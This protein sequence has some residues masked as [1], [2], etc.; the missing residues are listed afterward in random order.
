MDDG[1]DFYVVD[2]CSMVLKACYFLTNLHH[3]MVGTVAANWQRW[4]GILCGGK[5]FYGVKS[6]LFLNKFPPHNGRN[7]RCQLAI[8]NPL[9]P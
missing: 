7:R 5:L 6:M 9:N 2:C 1:V 4:C 3:V 8:R